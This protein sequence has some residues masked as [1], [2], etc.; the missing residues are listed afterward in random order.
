MVPVCAEMMSKSE[1]SSAHAKQRA[2]AFLPVNQIA[3][4]L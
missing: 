1:T 4:S 3:T 2:H